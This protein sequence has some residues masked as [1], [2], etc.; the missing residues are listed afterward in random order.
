[1]CSASGCSE[2]VRKDM[3]IINCNGSDLCRICRD[4]KNELANH[5][6]CLV[7]RFRSTPAQ[8]E[9]SQEFHLVLYSFLGVPCSCSSSLSENLY[10]DIC[11]TPIVHFAANSL[12]S[13]TR[14]YT[15]AQRTEAISAGPSNR[16]G[17]QTK[18][19]LILFVC[20]H[21]A[22]PNTS[23]KDS[24]TASC[25]PRLG[26]SCVADPITIGP[27]RLSDTEY[28]MLPSLA[29]TTAPDIDNTCTRSLPLVASP[30]RFNLHQAYTI[31]F[32]TKP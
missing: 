5:L 30:S 7:Q 20:Q 1:M 11:D 29:A 9:P 25:Q 10:R 8:H 3:G 32:S 31:L 13:S 18:A 6:P 23:S 28:P 4:S 19:A 16:P 14:L 17:S 15:N 24:G 27:G 22:C 2:P 12:S 26:R 21:T